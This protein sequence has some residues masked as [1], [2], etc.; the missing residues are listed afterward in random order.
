MQT[1]SYGYQLPET[2]DFG[3]V[4][5]PA[6]ESNIQRVNSHN[7][8]GV[9]SAPLAS[10]NVVATVQTVNSGSFSASGDKFRALVN[11]P[12]GKDFDNFAV[13]CKD[14]TSKDQMYLEVEKITDTTFYVYINIVQNVEVYFLS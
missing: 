2:T 5:F 14:P 7:H 8:D 11:T 9:N 1:L 4:W 12:S 6:L 3:D 13:I 10:A